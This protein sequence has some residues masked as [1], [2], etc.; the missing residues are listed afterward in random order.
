M[1]LTSY[2]SP[3]ILG[4]AATS[5]KMA[6]PSA[7]I[8]PRI[9]RGLCP[10][11]WHGR[12]RPPVGSADGIRG[13]WVKKGDEWGGREGGRGGKAPPRGQG[14]GHWGLWGKK[15]WW[16]GGGGGREEEEEEV[17]IPDWPFF[18]FLSLS[19]FS[20][21]YGSALF[22]G[23]TPRSFNAANRRPVTRADGG[24]KTEE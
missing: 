11:S 1:Q 6:P 7:P 10:P 13:S 5:P 17:A 2:A 9:R 19:S 16:G 24:E 22:S 20:F 12:K 3:A 14:R 4:V 18:F 23:I 15:G 21:N 8:L